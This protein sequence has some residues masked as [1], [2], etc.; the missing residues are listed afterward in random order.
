MPVARCRIRDCWV[1]LVVGLLGCW[2][3]GA[4]RLS[5]VLNRSKA[6]VDLQLPSSPQLLSASTSSTAN[7]KSGISVDA[8]LDENMCFGNGLP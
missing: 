1:G 5:C 4:L 8:V 6:G 3:V 2:V 7:P